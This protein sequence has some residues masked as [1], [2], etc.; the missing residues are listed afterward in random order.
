MA[1]LMDGGDVA[2]RS[3]RSLDGVTGISS[4][5]VSR[6]QNVKGIW[7]TLTFLSTGHRLRDENGSKTLWDGLAPKTNLKQTYSDQGT[8]KQPK[9]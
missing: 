1:K 6:Y 2:A 4:I 3:P 7:L 5:E 9:S 8:I